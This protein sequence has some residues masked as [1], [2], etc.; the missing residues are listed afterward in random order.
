MIQVPLFLME[1]ER[2]QQLNERIT[3]HWPTNWPCAYLSKGKKR[4]TSD[5]QRQRIHNRTV[6]ANSISPSRAMTADTLKWTVY[7]D[8]CASGKQKDWALGSYNLKLSESSYKTRLC[9]EISVRHWK[10]D[11][12]N[13]PEISFPSGWVRALLK[14]HDSEAA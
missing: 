6:Y 1:T 10:N 7:S 2:V 11:K 8:L 9:G 3:L 12:F 5:P 4:N 13:A 14:N